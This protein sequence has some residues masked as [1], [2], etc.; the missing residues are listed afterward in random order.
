MGSMVRTKTRRKRGEIHGNVGSEGAKINSY[1]RR[2]V[3]LGRRSSSPLRETPPR[4]ACNCN[5]VTVIMDTKVLIKSREILDLY[6]DSSGVL[7]ALI[8][9][10]WIVLKDAT[11]TDSMERV[12]NNQCV[13][14]LL[15]KVSPHFRRHP[16]FLMLASQLGNSQFQRSPQWEELAAKKEDI[17]AVTAYHLSGKKGMAQW[18]WKYH[19]GDSEGDETEPILVTGGDVYEKPTL[20]Q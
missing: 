7:Q 13:N 9:D 2:H 6:R 14:Y 12:V 11:D 3:V 4:D 5:Q 18:R 1:R 16:P 17:L 15:S 19:I 20:K 8:D 10:G